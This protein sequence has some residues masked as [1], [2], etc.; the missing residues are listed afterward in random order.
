MR[1]RGFTLI[2]LLVVISIISILASMIMPALA[3]AQDKGRGVA[4][5]NNERQIYKAAF[6]YTIGTTWNLPPNTIP[7]DGYASNYI[8]D[9]G[10]KDLGPLYEYLRSPGTFFCSSDPHYPQNKII[11][12]PT[13]ANQVSYFKAGSNMGS[14]D[15]A[16]FSRV[17]DANPV[18]RAFLVERSVNHLGG[19]AYAVFA[20]GH[21][22]FSPKCPDIIDTSAKKTFEHLYDG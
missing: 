9:G 18:T 21:A 15:K 4:C 20:D 1:K 16:D 7:G 2:E 19:G 3:K 8:S 17:L 5:I 14:P 22:K 10:I 12:Y 13:D 11:N 6:M